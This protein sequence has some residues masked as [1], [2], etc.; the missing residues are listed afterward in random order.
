MTLTNGLTS[1]I[2]REFPST[3]A[4]AHAL[5]QAVCESLKAAITQHGQ[6]S[7]A[8]SGGTTPALFLAELG[9]QTVSWSQV[10]VTLTDERWVPEG[11]S[12]ANATLLRRS[13]LVDKAQRSRWH[14]LYTDGQT[15]TQG[16]ITVNK[17]LAHFPWPLDVVVLGMGEDG[18]IA[19]LFPNGESWTSSPTYPYVIGTHS[20]S[21]EERVS[22][23]LDVLTQARH[24]YLLIHGS[25][26]AQLLRS[27]G[28][29]SLPISTLLS[30][31]AAPVTA[32][33]A[34]EG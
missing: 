32:F 6:A 13:L 11:D 18:H 21:M 24:I 2:Y 20:P 17:R 30:R 14:A 4:T 33:M 16:L 27:A 8:L 22:L 7:L 23:S 25:A 10:H 19:S 31:V 34:Q 29:L 1:V 9:Q 26:K 12:R 3:Q 5:S 28:E 15:R